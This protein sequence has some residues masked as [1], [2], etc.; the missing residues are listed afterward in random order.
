ML[1]DVSVYDFVLILIVVDVVFRNGE[2]F[3]VWKQFI[4]SL[5]YSL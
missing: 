2:R 1:H 3:D 4:Y 5:L